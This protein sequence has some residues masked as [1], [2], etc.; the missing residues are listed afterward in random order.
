MESLQYMLALLMLLFGP[1]L[2]SVWYLVHP[3]I[4]LWRRLGVGLSY[5]LLGLYLALGIGLLYWARG[6]LLAVSLGFSSA[7]FISGCVLLLLALALRTAL[8]RRLGSWRMLGLHELRG[9]QGEQDLVTTGIY[10][11]IRHPRYLAGMI[12]M[13]AFAL[14]SNYLVMYV[15]AV[16]T[17][18]ALYGVAVLEERELLQRFGA[19]YRRY[20]LAVPRFIPRRGA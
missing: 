3:L 20:M 16:L 8:E 6:W 13:W 14:L 12:L 2:F 18:P 9:A 17:I 7:G 19:R 1:P 11:H 15:V 4:G 10:S 5:L